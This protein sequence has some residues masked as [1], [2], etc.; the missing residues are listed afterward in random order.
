[1]GRTLHSILVEVLLYT[2]VAMG[3]AISC[4]PWCTCCR[5]YLVIISLATA[6]FPGAEANAVVAAAAEALALRAHALADEGPLLLTTALLGLLFP[7]Q[8]VAA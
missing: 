4:L 3:L 7:V 1:V 6:V 2:T 8:F 5:Q